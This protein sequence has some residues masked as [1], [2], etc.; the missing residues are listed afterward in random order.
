M[1]LKLA[2]P[3]LLVFLGLI[4]SCCPEVVP[5]YIPGTLET[6]VV[7][8]RV[9]YTDLEEPEI[10]SVDGLQ[11]WLSFEDLQYVADSKL[12]L[13]LQSACYATQ[14]CPE[15]GHGGLKSKVT[16]IK[17]TSSEEFQGTAS[18]EDINQF[19]HVLEFDGRD[20]NNEIIYSQQSVSSSLENFDYLTYTQ[21][22]VEIDFSEL[23]GNN[24]EHRFTVELTFENQST[25]SGS[26]G[27]IQF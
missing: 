17:I 26:T 9:L 16:S 18:G 7:L 1:N 20:E 11:I 3:L 2:F 23:P 14:P 22:Y 5:F 15:D 13:A 27:P 21:S 24:Q 6:E 19:F 4:P 25:L 10:S 12:V 8:D